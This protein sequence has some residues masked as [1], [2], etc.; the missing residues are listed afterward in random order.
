MDKDTVEI[1]ATLTIFP[2][3]R[4]L[5]C[6]WYVKGVFHHANVNWISLIGEAV[7]SHMTNVYQHFTI[8]NCIALVP[9]DRG[10]SK[11]NL[12]VCMQN[13]KSNTSRNPHHSVLKRLCGFSGGVRQEIWLCE[14]R[15][16][17][18]L[19]PTTHFEK[20]YSVFRWDKDTIGYRSIVSFT[21]M[22]IGHHN[23]ALKMERVGKELARGCR[24]SLVP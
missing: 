24:C 22:S 11:L 9:F 20:F 19:F 16:K 13:D 17:T 10:K 5:L 6:L 7:A 15:R 3:A 18:P 1:N 12:V 14:I 2:D 8:H 4:I 21:M 23:N